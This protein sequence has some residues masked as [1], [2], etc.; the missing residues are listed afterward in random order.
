ME[1][2]KDQ[3]CARSQGALPQS[4]AGTGRG[5]HCTIMLCKE[6]RDAWLVTAQPNLLFGGFLPLVPQGCGLTW[7]GGFQ[8]AFSGRDLLQQELAALEALACLP[9]GPVGRMLRASSCP[10]GTQWLLLASGWCHLRPHDEAD[11]GEMAARGPGLA[12]GGIGARSTQLVFLSWKAP[13]CT[14]V[15]QLLKHKPT[16]LVE[17]KLKETL[18]R[19]FFWLW[20]LGK[21]WAT[22][23]GQG[24]VIHTLL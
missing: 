5:S 20:F 7:K 16:N 13:T 24:K 1:G 12:A 17:M 23:K 6:Q 21:W 22:F 3:V 8:A 19:C 14:S 11:E 18:T 15:G 10:G 4:S 2:G 9:V